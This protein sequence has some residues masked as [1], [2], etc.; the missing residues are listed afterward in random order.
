MKKKGEVLSF[1]SR[2]RDRRHA[3]RPIKSGPK[4]PP[5]QP[6]GQVLSTNLAPDIRFFMCHTPLMTPKV[7][8]KVIRR[9]E[10]EPSRRTGT[11]SPPDAN[12]KCVQNPY[13]TPTL[14]QLSL[15]AHSLDG[16]PKVTIL[17]AATLSLQFS[18]AISRILQTTVNFQ[19]LSSSVRTQPNATERL[20]TRPLRTD[21]KLPQNRYKTGTKRVGG[22]CRFSCS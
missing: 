4:H 12:G 5:F 13:K 22:V 17:T 2:Q 6:W 11:M 15:L 14:F 8:Y 1:E 20:R 9:R 3:F 10:P 7:V 16:R 21:S 19:L 18:S